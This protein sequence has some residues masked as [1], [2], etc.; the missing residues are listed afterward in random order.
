MGLN[1]DLQSPE[2][3][4]VPVTYALGTALY[5][6]EEIISANSPAEELP[7]PEGERVVTRRT[8]TKLK[9]TIQPFE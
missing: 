9:E 8:D 7:V 6:I 5:Y 4:Y 2:A 1:V 3:G